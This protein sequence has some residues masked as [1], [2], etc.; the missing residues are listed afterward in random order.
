VGTGTGWGAEI[1]A[2]PEDAAPVVAGPSACV[3]QPQ[4]AAKKAAANTGLRADFF[5][6]LIISGPKSTLKQYNFSGAD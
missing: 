1:G 2:G 5:I 6:G 4:R 3:L